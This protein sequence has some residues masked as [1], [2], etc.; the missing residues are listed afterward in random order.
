MP[1]KR[2]DE[3]IAGLMGGNELARKF[4]CTRMTISNRVNRG[5]LPQHTITISGR[6]Y[7][8][9]EALDKWLKVKLRRAA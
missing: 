8:T 7:W 9:A 5:E 6:R 4:N 3:V 1:N 2:T